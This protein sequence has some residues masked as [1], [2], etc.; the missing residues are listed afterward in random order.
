[1]MPSA[2]ISVLFPFAVSIL[3]VRMAWRPRA[4]IFSLL[5]QFTLACALAIGI[6]SCTFFLWL[7]IPHARSLTLTIV[8]PVLCMGVLI[9]IFLLKEPETL[10]FGEDSGGPSAPPVRNAAGRDRITRGL[11]ISFY[12]ALGCAIACM[13]LALANKPLGLGDSY[14]IWNLRAR[15]LFRDPGQWVKGFSDLASWSHPD[16]PLLIPSSI[17]RL[18]TYVGEE[19][20]SV[21]QAIALFFTLGTVALLTASL[22]VLRSVH[23]GLLAAL[24]LLAAPFFTRLGSCQYADVPLGF[25]ILATVVLLSLKNVARN[26]GYGLTYL[27]GIMAGFA[28]WT[29]NEGILF[30]LAVF[31]AA[32]F[33]FSMKKS[34]GPWARESSFFL[35]GCLPVVGL[36]VYFKLDCG[37]PNDLFR[38]L[39]AGT[40][41]A[42]AGGLQRSMVIGKTFGTKIL[43]WGDGLTA[44]LLGYGILAGIKPDW[45]C[46]GAARIGLMVLFLMVAGYFAIYS[47][48]PLDLNRHLATSLERLLAQLW[49]VFLFT[50]FSIV[51]PPDEQKT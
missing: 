19:T 26:N 14:A 37:P 23:Q 8:E 28:A 30:V 45:R 13:M 38:S 2:L 39:D 6:S 36:L 5:L 17:A 32:S 41:V 27:S 9:T 21:P 12:I 35:A 1:M 34:Y 11:I 44:I 42:H 4:T 48:T 3:F 7:A 47:L 43:C 33:T 20:G 50:A 15:F 46:S 40:L 10:L 49:P 25:F 51:S 22:S 16:Y 29:N 31:V 18:W 24:F